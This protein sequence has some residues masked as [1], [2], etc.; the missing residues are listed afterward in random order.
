MINSRSLSRYDNLKQKL[1]NISSSG[2]C[3]WWWQFV[4]DMVDVTRVE[5][6]HFQP[7][8]FPVFTIINRNI[9]RARTRSSDLKSI[10]AIST[11]SH[12]TYK[13]PNR[14][15]YTNNSILFH[16]QSTSPQQKVLDI[17]WLSLFLTWPYK[18]F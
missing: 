15:D 13:S 6:L 4:C 18:S 9:E 12:W 16:W 3:W 7:E 11:P 1:D 10:S 2:W 8:L 14:T 17:Y 5:K